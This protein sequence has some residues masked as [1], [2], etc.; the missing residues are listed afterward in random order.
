MFNEIW[1]IVGKG[2]FRT[3]HKDSAPILGKERGIC[4]SQES[5][6]PPQVTGENIESETAAENTDEN[7]NESAE[8][9]DVLLELG[10]GPF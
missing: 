10:G 3:Y 4:A 5:A 1:K 8:F 6:T 2:I 9:W 7:E